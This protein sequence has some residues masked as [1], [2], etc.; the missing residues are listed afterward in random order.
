MPW[1]VKA[2]SELRL[3]FVH[4]VVSLHSPVAAAC[5][6]YGTSRKTG[7]KWLKRYRA[8]AGGPRSTTRCDPTRPWETSPP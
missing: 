8:A 2:V 6:E 7:H 1:G 5:G 3:A 4:E